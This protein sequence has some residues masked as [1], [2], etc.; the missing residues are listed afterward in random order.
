MSKTISL[1]SSWCREIHATLCKMRLLTCSSSVCN[2]KSSPQVQIGTRTQRHLHNAPTLTGGASSWLLTRLNLRGDGYDTA[3][4]EH[5]LHQ[6]T[7]G[8]S[9]HPHIG[10]GGHG[11]GNDHRNVAVD[12]S[13]S[14]SPDHSVH[15]G[16]R[17]SVGLTAATAKMLETHLL[18]K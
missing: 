10:V 8:P 2:V 12:Q 17:L 5:G 9:L 7:I 13:P 3:A 18:M 1:T 14:E 4:D 15:S 6:S 16:S 11:G